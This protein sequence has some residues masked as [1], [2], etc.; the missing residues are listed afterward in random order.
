MTRKLKFALHTKAKH[1]C[2]PSLDCLSILDAQPKVMNDACRKRR[3]IRHAILQFHQEQGEA[4]PRGTKYR[5]CAPRLVN[6][7]YFIGQLRCIGHILQS[8]SFSRPLTRFRSALIASLG[9]HSVIFTK[10]S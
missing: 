6:L 2:E 8:L 10:P 4:P 3:L 1:S 9:Y 7:A 5:A